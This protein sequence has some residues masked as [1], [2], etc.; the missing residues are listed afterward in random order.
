MR[1]VLSKW[2][3]Y[4]KVREP[5]PQMLSFRGALFNKLRTLV[6]RLT[7]ETTSPLHK[8]T[9]SDLPTM[10]GNIERQSPI[11]RYVCMYVCIS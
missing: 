5:K 8:R 7:R 11:A 9:I 3:G 1:D 4:Q 6:T 10:Y 2:F